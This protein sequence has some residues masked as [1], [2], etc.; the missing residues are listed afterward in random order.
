MTRMRHISRFVAA[1]AVAA[2]SVSCGDVVRDG[3][4]PMFL[5]VDQLQ[6]RRGGGTVV[7]LGGF[8]HSD[9][10]TLVSAPAPCSAES[11]CATIFNDVGQVTLRI[12]SKDVGNAIVQPT[13]STN[14]EVTIRGFHIT[15]KRSDGRNTPGVDV[16]YAWDGSATGTVP[17]GGTLV[18]SFE[19][20]RHVAKQEAPLAVL[21]NSA[22]II[23]T[24]AEIT[25]FG[26]DR[27]G[28]EIS[29]TGSIQVDFGNFGD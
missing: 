24:T 5:V 20:V 25:F 11:P 7:T 26:Q 14:N 10:Q 17:L 9:V 16:P 23:T 12:V 3:K 18:L 6:A 28:N 19:I 22:V 29:V 2:S 13:P 27:V 21:V 15:Y 8:L 4:S 1:A